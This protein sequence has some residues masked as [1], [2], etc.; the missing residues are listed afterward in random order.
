MWRLISNYFFA[1]SLFYIR[2]NFLFLGSKIIQIIIFILNTL[3]NA[4]CVFKSAP[5]HSKYS[6]SN[7]SMYPLFLLERRIQGEVNLIS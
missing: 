3:E 2:L 1:R 4:F 5:A 7:I 6:R